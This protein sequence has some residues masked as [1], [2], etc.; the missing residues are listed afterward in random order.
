MSQ[1]SEV[2]RSDVPGGGIP[3]L[4]SREAEGQGV[5][6]SEVQCIM[7]NG[8]MGT[9]PLW[10]DRHTAV[11]TLPSRNFLCDDGRIFDITH[12]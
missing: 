10:T 5:L 2:S 6:Y 1:G 3:G 4:M 11:K 12:E 9:L 8:H 7:D